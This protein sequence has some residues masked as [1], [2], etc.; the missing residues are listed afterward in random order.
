[1]A[2]A[3]TSATAASATAA[4][5]S[6]TAAASTAPTA[7]TAAS[8]TAAAHGVGV[9]DDEAAAHQ[10]VYVVYLGALDKGGAVGVDQHLHGLGVDHEVAV[11]DI[12]FQAEHV[13]HSAVFAGHHHHAQQRADLALFLD[14]VV[15]LLCRGRGNFDELS[16][17][18]VV[19]LRAQFVRGKSDS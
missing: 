9:A 12:L 18:Q 5:A 6:S 7:A 2:S 17:C 11:F 10:A 13:L 14:D 16:G 1:M 3:G 8:A 19:Y 4:A 15:E